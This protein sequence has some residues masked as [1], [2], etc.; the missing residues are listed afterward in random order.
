MPPKRGAVSTVA[1]SNKR[2]RPSAP[3]ASPLTDSTDSTESDTS[4]HEESDGSHNSELGSDASDTALHRDLIFEVGN[5]GRDHA[6][7]PTASIADNNTGARLEAAREEAWNQLGADFADPTKSLGWDALAW[8]ANKNK[9]NVILFVSHT[10]TQDLGAGTKAAA[11]KW[12][13]AIAVGR[14]A[15]RREYMWRKRNGGRWLEHTGDTTTRLI[16]ERVKPDW[17]FIVLY[18][19][20]SIYWKTTMRDGKEVCDTTGGSGHYEAVVVDNPA[21]PNTNL[22][23]FCTGSKNTGKEYEHL[24]S[25]A[26]RTLATLYSSTASAAME[27]HYN[28]SSK[29]HRYKLLDAVGVRVVGQHPRKGAEQN[30]LP[31]VVIG[32][33]EKQVGSSKKKVTHQLYTVWCP[34]GVLSQPCKVDQLTTLSINSFPEL[35]AFSDKTLTP[36]ERLPADDPKWQS[37]MDGTVKKKYTKITIA[38]AWEAHRAKF[39]Q[40]TVDQ[41]RKR[42]TAAREAATAA[43]TAIAATRADTRAALSLATVTNRP[44]SQPARSTSPSRIVEIINEKKNTYEVVWSQPVGNPTV[45]RVSKNH[46]NTQA[47]YVDIV[48]AWRAKQNSPATVLSRQ[49]MEIEIAEDEEVLEE[50]EEEEEAEEVEEEEEEEGEAEWQPEEDE[51]VD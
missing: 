1:A 5:S 43:D 51:H 46:M 2:P 37:P 16:P 39:K 25:L 7:P 27:A 17:P 41:S 15:E 35:L 38:K 8:L 6:S 44:A 23:L 31:G 47:E 48:L 9:C 29:I 36:E 3:T 26:N 50:Q 20:S 22:G 12:A 21:T 42:K 49:V 45:S 40:R 24:L 33:H 32:I 4:M 14:D 18:Q 28:S 19:R 10:Q 30:N 34:D 13:E 11:E